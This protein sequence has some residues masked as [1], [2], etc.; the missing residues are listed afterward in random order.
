MRDDGL[1]E[2]ES[3]SPGAW[4][5][6]D[7]PTPD[8]ISELAR[9]H[10]LDEGILQDATDEHEVPRL[11]IQD[12]I[13]YVFTRYSWEEGTPAMMTMSVLI[14]LGDSFVLTV[15]PESPAFVRPFI[16]EDKEFTTSQKVKFMIQLFGAIDD[17]YNNSLTR[18]R[19][20]VNRR[21]VA[22]EK[23]TESDILKFVTFE[24][25]LNEYLGALIPTSSILNRLLSGSVIDMYDE[26]QELIEDLKLSNAQLI[27]SS[28][29]N[30]KTIVNIR[31]AYS[32]IATN[33]LNRIIKLL[34][35]LTVVLTIPTMITG[36]FGMNMP[37]PWLDNPWAPLYMFIGIVLCSYTVWA[38]FSYK[39]WR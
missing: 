31:D 22:P 1:R 21:K 19:R 35:V 24:S 10:E 26:D 25:T 15:S 5:H 2:L 14:A 28:K 7:N 9:E 34:T 6:V 11:E 33:N 3:F 32:V 8:E 39:N 16:A 20:S 12:D 38:L 29:A 13:V 18:I 37:F 30:L 27:E 4:I 36:F 23:V 17:S